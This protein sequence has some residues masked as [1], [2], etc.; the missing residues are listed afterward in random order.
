MSSNSRSALGEFLAGESKTPRSPTAGVYL[1]EK[2]F[3]YLNLR[4]S[5][6]DA[7]F[8]RGVDQQLRFALPLK[9]NTT[10]ENDSLVAL[11]LGPNEW[12]LMTTFGD[13][14]AVAAGLRQAIEGSFSAVTDVSQ[15][16]TVIR[17][18]GPDVRNVL[19]KGCTLDL[20]PKVFRPGSCAQTLIAKV[21]VTIRRVDNAAAFDLIVRRSFAD[22]LA[23]WLKDAAGEFGFA[24]G[25]SEQP[26]VN[27][28]L[29]TAGEASYSA[30]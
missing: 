6:K 30:R 24:A 16:Q 28:P 18:S 1:T 15:G 29:R 20:H 26:G 14:T 19:S 23:Q 8:L 3:G 9:P 5:A 7:V 21:G 2:P 4:G 25:V 13:E 17:L 11:W 10:A 22:Y 12:L 27:G